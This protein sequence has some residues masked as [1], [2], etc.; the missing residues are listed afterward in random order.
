MDVNGPVAEKHINRC[1]HVAG[2]ILW[3]PPVGGFRQVNKGDTRAV[4][5]RATWGM[6]LFLR[7]YLI[8]VN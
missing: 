8:V 1:I 7:V 2:C 6:F 3:S 5:L 4:L